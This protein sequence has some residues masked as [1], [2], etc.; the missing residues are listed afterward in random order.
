[1]NRFWKLEFPS[2]SDIRWR[3]LPTIRTNLLHLFRLRGKYTKYTLDPNYK[4]I[5]IYPEILYRLQSNKTW[6]DWNF[7]LYGNLWITDWKFI[8][9]TIKEKNNAKWEWSIK[10][11][12]DNP[13][14]LDDPDQK[15]TNIE[16]IEHDW[17]DYFLLFFVWESLQPWNARENILLV[18][19]DPKN[20]NMSVKKVHSIQFSD[21]RYI[22]V[23][24]NWLPG[25]EIKYSYTDKGEDMDPSIIHLPWEKSDSKTFDKID[26]IDINGKVT[27]NT[28]PHK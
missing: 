17:K 25:I 20:N 12:I 26:T 6:L 5:N 1:M 13:L 15:P 27:E 3:G 18:E 23:I 21:E 8:Y 14:D 28:F 24:N 22:N 4:W 2:S 10:W 9:T 19:L 7:G 11:C 16:H